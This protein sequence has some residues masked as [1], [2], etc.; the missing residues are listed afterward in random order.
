MSRSSEF[1][2]TPWIVSGFVTRVLRWNTL[3]ATPSTRYLG[4]GGEGGG[5]GSGGGGAGAGGGGMGI[6]AHE[7]MACILLRPHPPVM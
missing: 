2:L 5:S 4:G 6:A 1:M 7:A 3:T